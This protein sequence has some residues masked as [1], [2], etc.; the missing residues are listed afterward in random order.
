MVGILLSYWDGLFSGA[1]L[2]LGRVTST[3]HKI[4]GCV[5]SRRGLDVLHVGIILGLDGN[6]AQFPNPNGGEKWWFT[7]ES[8]KNHLKNIKLMPHFPGFYWKKT[9][10][11]IWLGIF[12]GLDG[13]GIAS[14][15]AAETCGLQKRHEWFDPEGSAKHKINEGWFKVGPPTSYNW[16]YNSY[17]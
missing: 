2:V 8:V 3:N 1:M 5:F 4:L 16:V 12:T 9:P 15:I 13:N 17:N 11:I 10:R 14:E 6:G 7:V